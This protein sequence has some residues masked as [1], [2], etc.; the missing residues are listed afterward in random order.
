M[1][2]LMTKIVTG[3]TGKWGDRMMPPH[4]SLTQEDTRAIV[5]YI[6]SLASSGPKLATRGRAP[7]TQHAATPGGSY[8]LTAS[9]ADRPRNGIGPLSDTAVVVLRAPHI[10]A[11]EAL[12]LDGVGLRKAKGFD[13]ATR[14]QA[15]IYGANASLYLGKLDLTGVSRA[16][17]DLMSQGSRHP[18]TVELRADSAKG[19]LI[20]SADVRPTV[21]DA[22]YTQSVPVSATAERPVY[23]VLRGPSDRGIGQFN[24]LVTI[25]GV[26]FERK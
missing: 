24:P 18:F 3:G 20:G 19:A 1:Q 11:G 21:A 26:R 13:G 15:T 7:L 23:V 2:Q 14:S 10:Y 22:W 17:L 16:T 4:P 8:R 5:S 25:E 6:L 12:E 9:Y